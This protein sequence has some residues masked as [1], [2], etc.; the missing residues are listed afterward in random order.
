MEPL[1]EQDM[2]ASLQRD[3]DAYRKGLAE[4]VSYLDCLWCELYGSINSAQW[5]GEISEAQA[6]ACGR[7]IC[8]EADKIFLFQ[9]VLWYD[10]QGRVWAC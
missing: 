8:S 6:A 5:S 7:S 2:P 3:L 9:K 4:H 1:D 10:K